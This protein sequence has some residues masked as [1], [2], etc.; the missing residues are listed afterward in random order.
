MRVITLGGQGILRSQEDRG[1]VK[2]QGSPR[3]DIGLHEPV[4]PVLHGP[5]LCNEPADGA[6]RHRDVSAE[7]THVGIKEGR[8]DHPCGGDAVDQT[9]QGD[10][11]DL[12]EG[13]REE[14][15]Q[16]P[17]QV[18]LQLAEHLVGAVVPDFR[19][20]IRSDAHLLH[21]PKAVSIRDEPVCFRDLSDALA[22]HFLWTAFN[23]VPLGT[24]QV[25][26]IMPAD[27]ADL[28]R[29]ELSRAFVLDRF[30]D[31]HEIPFY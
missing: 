30:R 17:I 15:L 24:D 18:W 11:P 14:F 19:G 12:P 5:Q 3:H 23:R 22:G 10:R 25:D 13:V 28:R 31:S 4:D 26:V 1:T 21:E 27:A 2:H 29:T 16:L 20:D 9:E 6:L 8:L 7:I